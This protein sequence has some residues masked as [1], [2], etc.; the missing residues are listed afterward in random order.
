MRKFTLYQAA[1][2]TKI[3]R[4]KLE[5]AISEGYL[6]TVGGKGNIKC[7]I[8]EEELNRF[9]S[10]YGDQFIKFTFEDE[11]STSIDH[12][13]YI[14][15]ALHEKLMNE[16]E[17]VIRILELQ[18]EKLLPLISD[19]K[20]NTSNQALVNKIEKLEEALEN[21]IET[22]DSNPVKANLKKILAE[23]SEKKRIKA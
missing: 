22:V 1:R 16:K 17:R 13:E 5:Q 2:F 19:A 20:S 3:S 23:A 14:P 11:K 7:Y 6:K 21:A 4:Y 18:Q 9:L 12:E 8:V 10:E 15:K